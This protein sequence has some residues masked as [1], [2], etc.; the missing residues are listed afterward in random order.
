MSQKVDELVVNEVLGHSQVS[1]TLSV[2]AH[3]FPGANRVAPS[4]MDAAFGG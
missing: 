4:A 3:L 2:Y 1:L